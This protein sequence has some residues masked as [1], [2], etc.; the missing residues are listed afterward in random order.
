M[1]A[2]AASLIAVL[3]TLLGAGLSHAFQQRTVTRAETFNRN[4]KLRQE[5]LDAY[6]SFAGCLANYRR[7][8]VHLWF[9]EHRSTP[10][11]DPNEARVHSYERRS[12]AQEALFR[13]QML[14]A[15][16]HLV[17]QAESVF[18]GIDQLHRTEDRAEVDR[19]R[20]QTRRAITEFVTA[21][22]VYAAAHTQPHP[23]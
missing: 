10:P 20:E 18:H 3:G 21:A 15:D 8:L 6:C 22:K 11:A 12:E 23:A 19:R 2:V 4:E 13:V 17:G 1:E 7:A 16:E 9:C 5:R 14:T